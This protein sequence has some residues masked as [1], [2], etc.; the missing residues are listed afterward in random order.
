M[1]RT[2]NIGNWFMNLL[3]DH[4]YQ[5]FSAQFQF[6]PG[7]LDEYLSTQFGWYSVETCD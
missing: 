2:R 5:Q 4:L 6:K 7:K 3:L 1:H